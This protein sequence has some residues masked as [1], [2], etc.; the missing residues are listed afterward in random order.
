MTVL[1]VR[2]TPGARLS[3][4]LGP[5]GD[6]VKVAIAAPPEGGRANA[7]LRA[8]L[9]E[10]LGLKLSAVRVLRGASSRDKRIGVEGLDLDGALRRLL[11]GR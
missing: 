10:R 5:H 8:F 2:V 4:V 3:R 9:A 7:A 6:A 1:K 11:A